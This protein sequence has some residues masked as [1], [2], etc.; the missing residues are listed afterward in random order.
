MSGSFPIFDAACE[1]LIGAIAPGRALDIGA[2][3]G[4][5]ALTLGRLCGPGGVVV[6]VEP[7]ADTAACLRRSFERNGLHHARLVQAALSDREGQ[8][9][10]CLSGSSELNSLAGPGSPPGPREVVALRTL[11]GLCAAEG[12]RGVDFVK[13]DAEGEES[14]ILLGGRRFFAEESPLLM[15]E[16]KHGDQVNLPL[17]DQITGLGYRCYRLVPG[18]GLLAPFSAAEEPDPFQL[19]LFACK[20]DRAARLRAEGLLSDGDGAADGE[21]PAADPRLWQVLL[22]DRPF[23]RSL[24]RARGAA[25]AAFDARYA[26]ALSDFARAQEPCGLPP[27]A[28]LGALRSSFAAL[29][30]AVEERPTLPRAQS[31]ARVAADLGQRVVAVRLLSQLAAALRGESPQLGDEPFLPVGARFDHIGAGAAGGPSLFTYALCSVLEQREK[32]RAFSSYYTAESGAAEMQQI[33]ELGQGGLVDDEIG[34]RLQLLR[35]RRQR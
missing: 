32:L 13:L 2:N 8:G 20:A 9:E 19:N 18:L 5:Y 34:R 25:S 35:R 24:A 26:A 6:A 4:V 28:R 16:L 33:W 15:F 22:A 23:F 31:L 12:L 21:Q 1:H 11:D 27:G 14:R 17:I 10:L 7:G 29:R 30:R 3:Y